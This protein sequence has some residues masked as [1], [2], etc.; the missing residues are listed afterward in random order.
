M[1]QQG[2]GS[3]EREEKSQGENEKEHVDEESNV[4][5]MSDRGEAK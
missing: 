3:M 4:G 1:E 5:D 2:E